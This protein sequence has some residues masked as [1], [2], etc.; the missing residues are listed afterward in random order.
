MFLACTE[1]KPNE[2]QM[3]DSVKDSTVGTASETIPRWDPDYNMPFIGGM[4]IDE[5]ISQCPENCHF[6][7]GYITKE[8]LKT[9]FSELPFERKKE[10]LI[11]YGMR[12]LTPEVYE[13]Y[14]ENNWD[15]EYGYF[16]VAINYS[17]D[18]VSEYF[19][20]RMPG[21]YD[22]SKTSAEELISY[23]YRSH[24]SIPELMCRDS[25]SQYAVII[26]ENLYFQLKLDAESDLSILQTFVQY[27]LSMR[28]IINQ[29]V[30]Q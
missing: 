5:I 9:V 16:Q 8:N 1:Y 26:N 17:G 25:Y 4:S 29:E 19:N 10:K 23:G 18:N 28:E 20:I 12:L 21:P 15:N 6:M 27:S 13:K 2:Q 7:G 30:T 14:K 11:S 3:S 22:L 24:E